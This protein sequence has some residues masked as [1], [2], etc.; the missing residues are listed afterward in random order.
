MV[1][2]V[3]RTYNLRLRLIYLV[4]GILFFVLIMG[5]GY[6]QIIL[7]QRYRDQE[8]R[9][10]QRRI[11]LPGPRGN[12]YDRDGKLLVG[13]RPRFSAMV[14]LNE[15]RP[16]FRKEYYSLVSV[17]RKSGRKIKSKTLQLEARRAVVQRYLNRINHILGTSAIIESKKIERHFHQN[18]LLPLPLIKDLALEQYAKLIEQ[19]P[20]EYPVQIVTD[21]VRY[22][23]QGSAAAHT[24]GYVVSTLEL[25]DHNLPGEKL[26]TF[27]LKGSV[28]RTGLELQYNDVLQG[29]TGGEIWV[30]DPTGFQYERVSYQQPVKGKDLQISIDVALQQAAEQSLGDKTGAVV[31]LDVKTGEVY[32][33][34]SKPD[35]DLNELVPF[36]SYETSRKIREKEAWVNRATQLPYPPG[37]TFKLITAIAGLKSRNIVPET[38]V[39]CEGRYQVGNYQF[40]CHNL[41][42]H[43]KVDLKR[44][45]I[46]SCNVFFYECGIKTGITML[47]NEAR[48]MG[49]DKPTGIEIPYETRRM[50]VPDPE[51]KKNYPHTRERWYSGDTANMSIGQGFLLVTPLQMA[52]F[53]ASLARR[54]SITRPTLMHDPNRNGQAIDHGGV[55]LG[56]STRQYYLLIKGM[57]QAVQIGTARLAHVP[58]LR[59]A[60]KTGTAQFRAK[61]QKL[62]LA[63]F[64]GFAPVE[65]PRLAVVVM[66]EG[67]KPEDHYGGGKT[68][69]PIAKVIFQKFFNKNESLDSRRVASAY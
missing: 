12:I 23:P 2:S 45:I 42:G 8:L 39:V 26:K 69:A 5:L 56:L 28:G 51:W 55:P 62:N 38:T 14:Y 65:N 46:Q 32:V 63:W 31:A 48:F 44:A 41:S 18:L 34:A 3:Y 53:V 7:G 22:Y 35:F 36:I 37:S 20:V 47:S 57:E 68:A 54:E 1:Y 52:C 59:I 60:G 13:N 33:L 61:S 29:E 40:P 4:F 58:S 15:L 64:V 10:N 25:S 49:L 19:I 11:L 6:R 43:G 30:V 66:V 67:T 50:I 16:E 17:W 27:R 24:L 9:Q 21:S